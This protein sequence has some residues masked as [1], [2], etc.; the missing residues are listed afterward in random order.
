M[1]RSKLIEWQSIMTI[2]CYQDNYKKPIQ[3]ISDILKNIN[4]DDIHIVGAKNTILNEHIK[5]NPDKIILSLYPGIILDQPW[6]FIGRLR[7]DIVI[8]NSLKDYNE[9]KKICNIFKVR[10]NGFLLGA[11]WYNKTE[12]IKEIQEKR[13]IVFFEQIDIPKTKENRIKLLDKIFKLAKRYPN[14]NFLIKSREEYNNTKLSLYNLSKELILPKNLNF[15]KLQTCDLIQNLDLGISISSS[16]SIEALIAGKNYIIIS[17]FG[18][19]DTFVNFYK[20]SGIIKKFDCINL[21]SLPKLNPKWQK[22][23]ITNPY[24]SDSINELIIKLN[25]IQKEKIIINKNI[26]V[27]IKLILYY[28]K[29]FLKNPYLTFKKIKR[30]LNILGD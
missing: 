27:W 11:T 4:R 1:E 9:Y 25:Q 17:D 13:Y 5:N 29:L 30:T 24:N 21:S 28:Y 20:N 3:T 10:F 19:K 8:L 6:A 2:Y 7:A 22:Q 15:T 18:Y 23:N 26:I 16:T 12:S 14:R